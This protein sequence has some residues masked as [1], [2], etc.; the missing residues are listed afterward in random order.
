MDRGA[1]FS[2]ALGN[3]GQAMIPEIM[4]GGR[5][6]GGQ[7][8]GGRRRGAGV[9]GD[10]IEAQSG[11]VYRLDDAVAF[12]GGLTGTREHFQR[13]DPGF[14]DRLFAMAVEYRNTTG[15]AM[16]FQSG[17]RSEQENAQVGGTSDSLHL[18]GLAADLG[19]ATVRDLQ[20]RGLLE[21][22]GFR[23]GDYPGSTGS[24]IY[25]QGGIAMGPDSGYMATLHG[26]E[27][28]VPLP[29]GRSIPVELQP[30]ALDPAMD[31]MGQRIESALRDSMNNDRSS[32]ALE[33]TLQEVVRVMRDQLTI[34]QKM[35]QAAQN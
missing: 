31:R 20:S 3:F 29:D 32:A 25:R 27:A 9:R 35:L 33:S 13:L 22:F 17:H 4:G 30:G 11:R 15:R 6:Q 14:R 24:H 28:V 12:G 2:Q 5:G 7:G 18:R 21:Q 19:S 1:S 23:V 16:P 34:S 10:E 26:R 8:G